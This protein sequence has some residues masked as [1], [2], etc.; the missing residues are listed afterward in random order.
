MLQ[1]SASEFVVSDTKSAFAILRNT[2]FSMICDH[3]A[4]L[5]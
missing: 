3:G 4:D 2:D 5:R 1:G